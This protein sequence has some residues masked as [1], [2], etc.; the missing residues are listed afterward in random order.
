MKDSNAP[1]NITISDQADST[2]DS[3]IE[4]GIFSEALEAY[5]TAICLA[6]AKDLKVEGQLTG[7][8][9]K[10]D[11]AAVF[12]ADGKDLEALMQMFGY[13]DTE[14]VSQGKMLAEAGLLYMQKGLHHS[15][16]ILEIILNAAQSGETKRT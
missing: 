7:K 15:D 5:R 9:N 2:C 16:D 6:I 8:K 3:L 10:W 13:A 11:T 12:S 4:Q 1:K 14:V